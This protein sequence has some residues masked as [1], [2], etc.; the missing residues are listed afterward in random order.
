MSS[1]DFLIRQVSSIEDAVQI[2]QV[3]LL[4]WGMPDIEVI[5]SRFMHALEHNGALLLGAYVGERVVGF[6]FG[7]IGLTSI[8]GPEIVERAGPYHIYSAISGI[9]PEYQGSGVG[10]QLKMTQRELAQK[11]DIKLVTWTYDPLES[12]NGYFNV[13]KLGIVCSRYLRNYHGEMGGINAGLVTD[14]FY[15][16]WWL[17]SERVVTAANEP[18]AYSRE[19]LLDNGAHILNEAERSQKDLPLPTAEIT[20]TGADNLLI[21]IPADFQKVK[22]QDMALAI[23][24]RAHTRGLFERSFEQG[25]QVTGFVR[26][27]A[28][29]NFNRSYYLLE[30]EKNS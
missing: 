2:E 9:I 19:A 17:D 24:W 26:H 14:R 5:P 25:Y 8:I 27:E 10:Y 22:R 12:R 11:I 20:P 15:V 21:E 6:S 13:N 28:D 3:Q 30:K 4:A 18:L 29:E 1:T 7:L 16:E 23:E